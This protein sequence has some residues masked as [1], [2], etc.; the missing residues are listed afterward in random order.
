MTV[1][2]YTDV[3]ELV[4][5]VFLL[6]TA[7]LLGRRAHSVWQ[8]GTVVALL[9]AVAALVFTSRHTVHLPTS[10]ADAGAAEWAV[11]PTSEPVPDAKSSRAP[12][13]RQTTKRR[14][15]FT[16]VDGS[17][18]AP[19]PQ[20]P[21]AVRPPAGAEDAK[22]ATPPAP[23]RISIPRGTNLIVRTQDTLSSLGNLKGD[24][25]SASLEQ[26]LIADGYVI[27]EKGA[28][29]EGVVA[30]SQRAGRWKADSR[31]A[32]E[33]IWLETSGGQKLLISTNVHKAQG[34]PPGSS[35]EKRTGAGAVIGAVARTGKRVMLATRGEDAR[36]PSESQLVFYLLAP[37]EVTEPPS[38]H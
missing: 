5:M 30:L 34:G 17:D 14:T 33:L 2:T 4:A 21:P 24:T 6:A 12:I 32:I 37:L 11:P 20:I 25:F 15:V 19:G 3:M 22:I 18:A 10:S 13:R 23:R 7:I 8:R 27:A 29:V 9:V 36:I 1:S 35:D 16:A 28:T 38:L 31:L 26:P